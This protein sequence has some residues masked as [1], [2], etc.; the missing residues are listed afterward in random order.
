MMAMTG[1]KPGQ[2]EN[3]EDGR[4]AEPEIKYRGWKAMPYVIGNETFEKLGTIG[5]AANLLVYLTTI[6]H[7]KSVT[8]ATLLNIFSGTTN[9]TPLLGAFLSDTYL[10][11]YITLGCA[12]VSSLLGMLLLTL[13]AAIS[14]LHPPKCDNGQQCVGPSS[15]QLVVLLCSFGFLVIG[16]GGIRPCNLAFGADQFNP[17]TE[18]GRR[19]INSFFNWYYFTFTGAMMISSTFIIYIQSNVSWSLGLAIPTILMF[20]SCALFFLGTRLYV[21]VKPEGSPFTSIAQVLVV[22]FRKRGLK[23][24]DDPET[25]LFNPPHLSSLVSKLPF[26][27]QFRFLD[28]AAIM[29]PMDAIKPN[30]HA[31]NP[32]R[33]CSLQQVEQVKCL[34]RII[35]IWASGTILFVALVQESS[36]VVFQGL[37]ADRHFGKSK[38]EIPAASFT[39]FSMLALTIWIPV[40][41]RI[42]V[43]WLRRATGKE[44][45]FTLLQR[46]G[47]GIVLTVVAMVVSGLVEGRRR[48]YALHRPALGIAPSGGTISSMSSFWLV[49]QLVL[50][51]FAEAF[52]LI[53]QVEFYYKQFPE[54]MRSLA[55]GVFFFGL[56]CANY[57][58]GFMVTV[59]HRT[60]GHNGKDN[61]L[62]NDLNHGRLDYFYFLIALMEVVNFVF[63]IVF[64][65]WYRYK[66]LEDGHEIALEKSKSK[67]SLV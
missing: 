8:A 40:Y 51:G 32:W 35:P 58:S 3:P 65:N 62:A 42:L 33:L 28:K 59:I 61:W 64:A 20:F 31:A 27:N 4:E 53:G 15:V 44:A 43:P 10:G 63:F 1:E 60:T 24:P 7:L 19:G 57:L 38:F 9:L 37:Q 6:F 50:L 46:M 11:R 56:A 30:G 41:D 67:S 5:T 18:I 13:T 39:V 2:M 16:A 36:F 52:N 45:G 21:K 47:I 17:H 54:N 55:G 12:S 14:K 49:P 29:T 34:A 23:Q 26:T 25:S 66:G 22:A 48:S